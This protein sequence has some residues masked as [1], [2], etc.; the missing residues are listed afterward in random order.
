[1]EDDRYTRITL[2]IPKDLHSKLQV[3]ADDTSKS[4]NA[5]IV[6]RLEASYDSLDSVGTIRLLTR[7]EYQLAEAEFKLLRKQARASAL[8]HMVE[9]LR[10][11]AIEHVPPGIVDPKLLAEISDWNKVIEIEAKEDGLQLNKDFQESLLRL[12]DAEA[13]MEKLKRDIGEDALSHPFKKTEKDWLTI[14]P[15]AVTDLPKEQTQRRLKLRPKKEDP[16]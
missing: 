2:R 10:V 4:I 8:A 11:I 9:L 12:E 13:R 1:M 15:E 3:S 6:S 14:K 7:L 5:E 16:K